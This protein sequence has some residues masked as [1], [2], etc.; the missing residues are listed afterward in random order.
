MD[1]VRSIASIHYDWESAPGPE[2]E[3][4]CSH[5][6]KDLSTV[7]SWAVTILDDFKCYHILCNQL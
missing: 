6:D 5:W 3:T 1:A 4:C 2:A 7:T